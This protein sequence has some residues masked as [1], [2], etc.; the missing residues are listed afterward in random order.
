MIGRQGLGDRLSRFIYGMNIAKMLGA[1]LVFNKGDLAGMQKEGIKHR[2]DATEYGFIATEI[3]GINTNFTDDMIQVPARRRKVDMSDAQKISSLLNSG[4]AKVACNTLFDSNILSCHGWCLAEAKYPWVAH[5]MCEL[6]RGNPRKACHENSLGNLPSNMINI[7]WVV[8]NGDI[9]LH[10]DD[11]PY[12]TKIYHNMLQS[13][14]INEEDAEKEYITQDGTAK[15]ATS[16]QRQSIAKSKPGTT[17]TYRKAGVATTST[18]LEENEEE[19]EVADTEVLE[20]APTATELSGKLSEIIDSI[21]K[22]SEAGKDEKHKKHAAKVMKAMEAAKTALEAM[23]AHEVMLEEKE[24]EAE[25]KDGEKHLKAIEKHLGKLIKDKDAV[26]K[27]MKKMP[28]E[29]VVQMKKQAGKELDEEKL[30]KV[31]LKHSLKEGWVKK[32]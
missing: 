28:V 8:R 6:Q 13:L 19:M 32:N 21:S 12:F 7:A 15:S 10:C 25:N 1:A 5:I 20:S 17:I 11:V 4:K 31:M 30:A 3:L 18:T 24:K 2:K 23:T 26:S 16:K 27:I 9:C 29:K 14:D 22:I